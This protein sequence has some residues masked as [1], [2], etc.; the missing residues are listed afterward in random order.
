LFNKTIDKTNA[1]IADIMEVYAAP[2]APNLGIR[3]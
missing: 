2:T 1:D 3:K